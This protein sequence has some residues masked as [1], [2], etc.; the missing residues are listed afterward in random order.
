MTR[1]LADI[2]PAVRG[3]L[4]AN[5][6][7]VLVRDNVPAKWTPAQG[8]LLTVADDSGPAHWPVKSQHMLRLTA[9]AAGRDD[10]VRIA[11]VAA[12]KLAE[13]NPR[14]PGVANI[15]GGDMGG[16]LDGRDKA[17]GAMFASVLLTAQARTVEV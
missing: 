2:L 16:V 8:S 9:Y 5:M 7:G 10:A 6:A 15:K 11:T 14:P 13:S 17:T 4:D 3:W 12:G 1:V